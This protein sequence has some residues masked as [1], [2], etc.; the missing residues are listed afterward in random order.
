M[1]MR[2]ELR[3]RGVLLAAS[4]ICT[5]LCAGC[6]EV[7]ARLRAAPP[8]ALTVAIGAE[9]SGLYASLYAARADGDFTAGALAVKVHQVSDPLAAL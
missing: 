5:V 3:R 9:P 1:P 8:R 6:G 2:P 7:H 4:L